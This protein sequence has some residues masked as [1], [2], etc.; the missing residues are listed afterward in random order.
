MTAFWYSEQHNY[1]SNH[2]LDEVRCCCQEMAH[3]YTSSVR[4]ACKDRVSRLLHWYIMK[5]DCSLI[6]MYI[7]YIMF[8]FIALLDGC[9]QPLTAHYQLQFLIGMNFTVPE[10]AK[11]MGMSRAT[12]TR[13]I[14]N[15]GIGLRQLYPHISD[16]MLDELHVACEIA[17]EYPGARCRLDQSHSRAR[18]YIYTFTK[19]QV[20]HSVSRVNPIAFAFT[21]YMEQ[22]MAVL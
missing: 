5:L 16:H 17:L 7:V 8:S 20:R 19:R 13:Q 1:N 21:L 15:F 18:G 22:L 9:R 2:G 10:I 6:Y 3:Q 14:C 11:L 12:V 4:H